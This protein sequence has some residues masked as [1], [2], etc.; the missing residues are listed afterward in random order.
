MGKSAIIE[1]DNNMNT[2]PDGREPNL[3][4]VGMHGRSEPVG[5]VLRE[6]LL[7]N[8]VDGW[9]IEVGN[10]EAVRRGLRFIKHNLPVVFGRA[11]QEAASGKKLDYE[12][13]RANEI[14]ELAEDREVVLDVHDLPAGRR[15]ELVAIGHQGNPRL[16]RVANVLGIKN[17]IVY[18]HGA[19]LSEHNPNALVAEMGRGRSNELI[20]ENVERLL[21]C[22]GAVARGAL[23][24]VET[25]KFNYFH[26]VTEISAWRAKQLN[27]SSYG[28]LESFEVIPD[29]LMSLLRRE[30]PDWQQGTY[31]ADYWNGECSA[32]DWF[33]SVL[34][35]IKNP[36]PAFA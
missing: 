36:F 5:L 13:E 16:L 21:A 3:L 6:R 14:R 24:A 29:C 23:P 9:N 1:R 2:L 27:L 28:R 7:E 25:N 15:G 12:L 26:L 34:R 20:P 17:V 30:I 33:G 4:L 19:T 18:E 8:P 32:A 22:L 11:Q 35:R 10:E 31:V